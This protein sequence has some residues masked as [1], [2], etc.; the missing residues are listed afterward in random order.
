MMG[1]RTTLL[2]AA[3]AV[4]G[5]STAV[6]ATLVPNG[7]FASPT[8]S[9]GGYTAYTTGSTGI[10]NFTV[11]GTGGGVQLL[12]TNYGQANN[13]QNFPV[14][15]TAGEQTLLLYNTAPTGSGVQ[16]SITTPLGQPETISF[17]LG[18]RGNATGT[19][20]VTFD[21]VNEGSFASASNGSYQLDSFTS[22][23]TGNPQVL[24]IVQATNLPVLQEVAVAAP[25]PASL[26]LLSFVS[27]GLLARRRRA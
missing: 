11:I 8:Q 5:A 22:V 23:G 12:G 20:S 25:E 7:N 15:P 26:G 3:V 18:N 6:Q 24:S 14:V 19:V 21:G 17:Q 4:L 16:T 13:G 2:A 27:L 10:T 9:A 1:K